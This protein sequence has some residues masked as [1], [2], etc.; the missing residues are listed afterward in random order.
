MVK[1]DNTKVEL[2]YY[3]WNFGYM[4]PSFHGIRERVQT[5]GI[6]FLSMLSL[7]SNK[8]QVL[9]VTHLSFR[10][11][12]KSH[13]SILYCYKLLS[14][15]LINPL[16]FSFGTHNHNRKYRKLCT[17]SHTVL[18]WSTKSSNDCAKVEGK[19]HYLSVTFHC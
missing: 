13:I 14:Y 11:E 5:V 19:C 8:N 9:F 15:N 10:L 16:K 3:T 7:S 17:F 12:C 1:S 2:C 4:F 6:L 18:F